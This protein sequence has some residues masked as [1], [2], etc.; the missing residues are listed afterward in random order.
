MSATPVN[1][2]GYFPPIEKTYGRPVAAWQDLI[3]S[4]A[5]TRHMQLVAWLK[6]EHGLDHGH[7]NALLAHTLAQAS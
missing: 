4:R 2:P 3:R 6:A 5:L 1:G 7:A